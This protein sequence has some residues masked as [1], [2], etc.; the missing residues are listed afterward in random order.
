MCGWFN[1]YDACVCGACTDVWVLLFFW[2]QWHSSSY[3]CSML[4]CVLS[5]C[6]HVLLPLCLASGLLCDHIM[7]AVRMPT[8]PRCLHDLW[9]CFTPFPSHLPW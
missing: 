5:A 1:V 7:L 2:Y 6:H 3:T 4:L 8:W 9:R